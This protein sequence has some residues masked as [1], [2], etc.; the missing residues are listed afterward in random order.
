[1]HEV[2]SFILGSIFGIM[3]LFILITC[4]TFCGK[5]CILYYN[6]NNNSYGINDNFIL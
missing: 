1:M 6:Q 4:L 2:A 3:T 5:C